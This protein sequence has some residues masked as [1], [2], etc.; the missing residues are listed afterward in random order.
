[1]AIRV[2]EGPTREFFEMLWPAALVDEDCA[3]ADEV[4][5]DMAA[6]GWTASV[7]L[8]ELEELLGDAAFA[9]EPEV[10]HI[11][12]RELLGDAGKDIEQGGQGEIDAT[13][14]AAWAAA[15][16]E[17]ESAADALLGEGRDWAQPFL[18][19]EWQRL[20]L[21]CLVIRRRRQAGWDRLPV[22]RVGD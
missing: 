10:A 6:D 5:T 9:I 16:R 21:R 15:S 22:R 12:V 1:M 7:P 3:L 14:Q 11:I 17:G 2:G 13:M 4:A 20:T 18:T 19:D 8:R